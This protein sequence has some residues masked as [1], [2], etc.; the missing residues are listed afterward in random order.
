MRSDLTA[1]LSK[2]LGEHIE[3]ASEVGGGDINRAYRVQTQHRIVF[4][5]VND[6]APPHM[7]ECEERGLATLRDAHTVRVPDV[8]GRG[9]LDRTTF[10]V[11][12]WIESGSPG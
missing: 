7:F 12:E 3:R 11:L 1:A 9:S 4:V 2:R 10:L 5:K 6:E 8:L